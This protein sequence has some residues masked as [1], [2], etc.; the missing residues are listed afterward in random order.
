MSM[1]VTIVLVVGMKDSLQ[2]NYSIVVKFIAVPSFMCVNFLLVYME[3]IYSTLALNM[4]LP[5]F[6]MWYVLKCTLPL[7]TQ[8]MRTM[9]SKNCQNIAVKLL[10]SILVSSVVSA[11]V[12]FTELHERVYLHCSCFGTK[13]H[14]LPTNCGN[15]L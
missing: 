11:S 1:L 7:F 5:F 8:I 13:I 4:H 3:Y 10:D 9:S 2:T 6:S 12:P 15:L 14:C